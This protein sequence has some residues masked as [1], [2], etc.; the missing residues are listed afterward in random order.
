MLR[1]ELHVHTNY[2]D[3][4]DNPKKVIEAAIEKKIDVLAI[5][6]HDCVQASLEAEEIVEEEKLPIKIITATE[7]STSNGHLL[8]Y[9]IRK[10]L[11]TGLDLK[12]ACEEVQKLGGIAVIAHPFDF[13][14]HGV[15]KAKNFKYADGIEV[16]NAKSFFNP[17]AKIY[18]EKYQKP[19]IAGSDAHSASSVG[20]AVCYLE[21]FNLNSILNAKIP[22]INFTL[23]VRCLLLRLCLK[24]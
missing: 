20:I 3:G 21:K 1:A 4:K 16:F 12:E 9:G 15:V 5:T 13:L 7:I 11:D 6:D 19:G 2:S 22:K 24:L 14:R 10:D 18:A 8:A 23:K 17:I